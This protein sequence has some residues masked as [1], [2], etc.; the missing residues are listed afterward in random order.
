MSDRDW[1]PA[2]V[3]EGRRPVYPRPSVAR[4]PP[5]VIQTAQRGTPSRLLVTS[6]NIVNVV[7]LS[8]IPALGL[9]LLGAALDWW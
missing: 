4:R 5:D 8:T 3:N 2:W 6:R 7:M 1:L 9:F